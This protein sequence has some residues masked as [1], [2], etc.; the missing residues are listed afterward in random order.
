MGAWG[1]GLYDS[2]YARD[3]KGM[4]QGIWRAPLSDE[5]LLAEIGAPASAGP[6]DV[7][8]LD[9]WLVLA[10][11]LERAGMPRQDVFHRAMTIVDAGEDLAALEALGSDKGVIAK[12]RKANA[13]LVQRLRNPRPAKQRR[14]LAK[15]QPLLF[16]EGDALTWPTDRG[17]C[18]N[19]YVHEDKLHLLGGFQQDGWGF[20]IVSRVGH[21][22]GVLAYHSVQAL[23]W[24]R[25]ERPT[26]ELAGYCPRSEH[27]Y[28]TMTPLHF[29][30]MGIERLGTVSAD[31]LGPPQ[32]PDHALRQSR[33]AALENV[34][35][36]KAFGWDAFNHAVSPGPKFMFSAPLPTPGG[37]NDPDQRPGMFDEDDEFGPLPPDRPASRAYYY[38]LMRGKL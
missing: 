16:E 31:A 29:T 2:D 21:L 28:G 27:H 34:G 14:P 30:R 10:D 35:L 15:P 7:D 11:Q 20:G 37:S 22:Y 12:R 24:R 5:E 19:P 38:T 36:S 23:K 26:P 18:I 33:K 25:A 6:D 32:D 8:A 17:D 3:L 4:I 9:H 13:E 1:G